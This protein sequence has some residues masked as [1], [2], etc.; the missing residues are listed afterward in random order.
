MQKNII[1]NIIAKREIS[2]QQMQF[3][4][5]LCVVSSISPPMT[6]GGRNMLL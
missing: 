6:L 1:H 5:S 4:I 2:F 3:C